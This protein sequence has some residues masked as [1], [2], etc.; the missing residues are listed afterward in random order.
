ML[1]SDRLSY[2]RKQVDIL[3]SEM[4]QNKTNTLDY[5]SNIW[6]EKQAFDYVMELSAA[7]LEYIRIHTTFFSECLSYL[8]IHDPLW[9]FLRDDL[10]IEHSPII[11]EYISLTENLPLKYHLYEP[12][13]NETSKWTGVPYQNKIIGT[14]ILLYQKIIKRFYELGICSALETN[15]RPNI[16]EIGAGY[17]GFAAQMPKVMS[18]NC[19]YIIVDI[20]MS[21]FYSAIF[22]S[23]VYPNRKLYIATEA[24][25][26]NI[27]LEK[28]TQEY[29]FVLI[30][31]F[32]LK[33]MMQLPDIHLA[34]SLFTFEEL[35]KPQIENYAMFL[36][37]KLMGPLFLV[38]YQRNDYNQQLKTSFLE[39]LS[40]DFLV[41]LD[42]YDDSP[43]DSNKI[44]WGFCLANDKKQ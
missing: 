13:I 15:K 27:D 39:I 2:I 26:P 8:F 20:P 41:D 7:N 37:Y 11:Q 42:L 25:L 5:I 23:L 28:I 18:H 14:D 4:K 21:L 16:L 36:S 10:S 6:L 22:L 29:D 32:A 12:Y 1:Y 34:I 17:G 33:Y 19:C 30:P 24:E 40:Q 44:L 9:L 38:G 3:Y 31:H 43:D 35:P